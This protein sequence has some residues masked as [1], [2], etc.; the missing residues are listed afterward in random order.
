[1]TGPVYSMDEVAASRGN[2]IAARMT[3]IYF[4][5][6]G[7]FIKIGSSLQWSK[8]LAN[9]QTA[10]P[11]IVRALLVE[12]NNPTFEASLHRRFKAHHHR[13]E[14]FRDCPEIR[15]FIAGRIAMQRDIKDRPQWRC[16]KQF[17]PAGDG[18][19]RQ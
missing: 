9:I 15:E 10:S 14:W 8:R 19:K 4:F 5:E 18:R 17:R 2:Q 16:L 6:A 1:M 12:M 13:G 3:F 11:H 7:E